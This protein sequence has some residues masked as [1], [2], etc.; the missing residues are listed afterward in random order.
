MKRL[1]LLLSMATSL[2]L[3]LRTWAQG[4]ASSYTSGILMMLQYAQDD[5]KSVISDKTG[6]LP[7][8]GSSSYGLKEILDVGS[9]SIIKSNNANTAFYMCNALLGASST[10]I[11]MHDVLGLVN[12][13]AKAGKYTGEDYK[14]ED[15][16]SITEVKDTD[17]NDVMKL[18]SKY[19]NDGN[20]D[21]DVFAILIYGK[22]MQAKMKAQAANSGN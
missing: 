1:F 16:K 4:Q 20:D 2:T 5:F 11:L 6:D 3:S 12:M 22:S 19:S 21:N 18:I 15:G 17:G 7:E 14:T 10:S 8:M 9:E 13:Y